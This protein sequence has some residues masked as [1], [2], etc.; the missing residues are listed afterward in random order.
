MKE[1][2]IKK[3]RITNGNMYLS[4]GWKTY[5]KW[6]VL[7][8]DKVYTCK[9][10]K[11][12]AEWKEEHTE[13]NLQRSKL[14]RE[15]LEYMQGKVDALKNEGEEEKKR[16]SEERRK[17]YAEDKKRWAETKALKYIS[18]EKL[19]EK[20]EKIPEGE[21]KKIVL[22]EWYYKQEEGFVGIGRMVAVLTN[23]EVLE[24]GKEESST[25]DPLSWDYV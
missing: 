10:S 3:T 19:K 16:R 17:Q 18:E 14:A 13:C 5:A 23:T 25:Y 15:I 6:Y 4:Y 12:G 1:E 24:C 7:K 9:Y 22:K 11:E 8:G 2:Y 21:K 20:M